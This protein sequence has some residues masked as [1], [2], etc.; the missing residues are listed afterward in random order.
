MTGMNLRIHLLAAAMLLCVQ[1]GEAGIPESSLSP[2][3]SLEDKIGQMLLVGFRGTSAPADSVITQQLKELNLGGVVLFDYDV[4]SSSFPR[5]I[6]SPDQLR[7]LIRDLQSQAPTP[8][9]VAV[10]AE[11]GR[12]NRLK[13]K[14]GFLDIPSARSVGKGDPSAARPHYIKLGR[15]LHDLGINLNLAPVVD[16]NINPENPIIGSLE[17][18]YSGDTE[19][20]TKMASVFIRTHHEYGIMTCLK[21]FPGHGSSREDSHLGLV[22]VTDTFRDSEI[23]PYRELIRSSRVDTVMTA[24]VMHKGIDP[25]FPATLSPRFLQDMLRGE[26]GF[27][28]VIVSDDMQMGAISRNFGFGEAL[29]RAVR[30]GCDILALANNGQTFDPD[31]ALKAHRIL[32]EAVRSGKIQSSTIEASYGRITHLKRKYGLIR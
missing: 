9:L 10:D 17:R 31:V 28:G 11:G 4:P 30:A 20:V 29:I 7:R 2:Q 13:P 12:I 26:L 19:I 23:A 5:N 21:H 1:V 16:L 8:L 18:S 27:L 22:D 14:Y 25:E 15:Q 6:E 32:L 3:P 24:H